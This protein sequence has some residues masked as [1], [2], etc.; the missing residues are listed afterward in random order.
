MKIIIITPY[1]LQTKGGITAVV[2]SLFNELKRNKCLVKVLTPDNVHKGNGEV[3]KLPENRISLPLKT[4]RL[5]RKFKPKVIHIHS[6]GSLL[7]G[8]VIYKVL[9]NRKVKII[10]T[11][12]TQPHMVSYFTNKLEK[13]RGIL[14]RA[15]FNYLLKYCDVTCVSKS[16]KNSLQKTG[17]KIVNSVIIPNGVVAKTVNPEEVI[18][19][20]QKYNVNNYPILCMIASFA[21]DWKVKGVMILIEAFK[22]VLS[23]QPK[24]RLLVVGDGHYRAML[25]DFVA[26]EDLKQQ[27]I[28]TGNMDNPFIALFVCDIYCHISLNEAYPV[29]PLEAMIV[30]K[31]VIA[32]NDGGLPEVITDGIDGILVNSNPDSVAKAILSLVENSNLRRELSEKAVITA[33]VKFSWKEII[34]EYLKLY[35]KEL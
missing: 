35:K 4:I 3:I 27:V 13:E 19:F 29:A 34:K 20:K 9:F 17:V 28:F 10:F 15:I 30:G 33:K 18:D 25:E 24:A 14:K 23:D 6:H 7:L 8:P 16:L 5:L 21:W 26:K 2:Y 22:K 32:S 11:F 1:W 12:H 31:P